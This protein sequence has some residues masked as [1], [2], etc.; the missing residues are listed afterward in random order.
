MEQREKVGGKR[1]QAFHSIGGSP[2]T[3][4]FEDMNDTYWTDRVIQ[5][6]SE[7]QPSRKSRKRDNQLVSM[8]QDKA[9]NKSNSRKRY[10]DGNYGLSAENP[11]GYVDEN[12]PAELVM[13]FPVVDCVPSEISLNKMFRRFGPLKESETEV[14]KDTNRAR[15]VF[16]KCSD[17]E[18]AYGSAPKFNIFGSILVNYQLNYTISVPF[19]SQPMI[20]L[21][22]G[23]LV[24]H[25]ITEQ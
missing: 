17:A 6:G 14:D 23:M 12:A 2:E 7:E 25:W 16:K 1:R 15:V 5:N 20:T 11:A 13:H 19:K 9:L 10:S 4:E 8:D 22:D 18:A 21:Q 24:A 3:F